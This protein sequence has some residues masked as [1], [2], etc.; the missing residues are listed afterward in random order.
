MAKIWIPK[1]SLSF[2]QSLPQRSN[3]W[4]RIGPRNDGCL[5]RK[6]INKEGSEQFTARFKWMRFKWRLGLEKAQRWKLGLGHSTKVII[7][8]S[9]WKIS[10]FGHIYGQQFSDCWWKIESA[11]RNRGYDW[12]LRHLNLLMDKGQQYKQIQTCNRLIWK[13]SV[14]CAWRFWAWV[15]FTATRNDVSNW[16]FTAHIEAIIY[17]K[18]KRIHWKSSS[19]EFGSKNS[20]SKERSSLN[21]WEWTKHVKQLQSSMR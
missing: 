4:A 17:Q 8:H 15:S 5:R 7:I 2:T 12:N 9:N 10:T 3:L 20:K 13:D 6:K 11:L 18:I 21:W 1:Q 16:P 14:I 19:I